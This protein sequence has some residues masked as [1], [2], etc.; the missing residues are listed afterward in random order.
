MF[1]KFTI[2]DSMTV[3]DQN[4]RRLRNAQCYFQSPEQIAST[5]WPYYTPFLVFFSIFPKHFGSFDF[6]RNATSKCEIPVQSMRSGYG[7]RKSGC[8]YIADSDADES[9]SADLKKKL[10]GRSAS[11][12]KQKLRHWGTIKWY[13]AIWSKAKG[14]TQR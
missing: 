10:S 2:H 11:Q 3:S 4:L 9:A 1:R 14:K 5:P 12:Q 13:L 6:G 7:F 8:G